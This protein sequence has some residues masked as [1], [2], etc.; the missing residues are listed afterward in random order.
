MD[1]NWRWTPTQTLY[2]RHMHLFMCGHCGRS[3]LIRSDHTD[4]R[5]IRKKS[6]PSSAGLFQFEPAVAACYLTSF[7]GD[8]QDQMEIE[9]SGGYNPFLRQQLFSYTHT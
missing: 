1:L 3:P 8:Q 9:G 4:S 7:G 6:K 2:I 5:W